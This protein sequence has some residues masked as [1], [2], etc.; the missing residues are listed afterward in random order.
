MSRSQLVGAAAVAAA[1]AAA[2]L[3]RR[4]K[5]RQMRF[6]VMSYNVQPVSTC[7][8]KEHLG[9][10][11]AVHIASS[12]G[13]GSLLYADGPSLRAATRAYFAWLSKAA[14]PGPWSRAGETAGHGRQA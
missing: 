1:A 10:L 5:L 8:I 14:K 6:C 4:Y 7:E 12:R 11:R 13:K 2:V 3:Y 9:F